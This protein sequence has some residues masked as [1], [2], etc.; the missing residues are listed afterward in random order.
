MAQIECVTVMPLVCVCQRRVIG[1]WGMSL[2]KT[3]PIPTEKAIPRTAD[4]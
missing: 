1:H 3:A 4:G 2:K